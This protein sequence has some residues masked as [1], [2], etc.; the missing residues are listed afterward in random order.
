MKVTFKLGIGYVGATHQETFE[1]EDDYTEN[2]LEE[3]LS[4][5]AHNYIDMSFEIEDEK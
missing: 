2:E 1:F 4:N 3:E 5:W